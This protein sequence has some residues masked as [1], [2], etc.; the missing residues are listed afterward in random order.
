MNVIFQY[1]N[2]FNAWIVSDKPQYLE[3]TKKTALRPDINKWLRRQRSNRRETLNLC[4][5][6]NI[7]AYA[8]K[9][10]GN[11]VP[12]RLCGIQINDVD[13]IDEG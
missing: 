11:R 1:G 13:A 12:T 3:M 5:C 6:F 10:L 4:C 9:L 8:G 2:S 7:D